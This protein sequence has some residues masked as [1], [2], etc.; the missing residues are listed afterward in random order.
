MLEKEVC[1]YEEGDAVVTFLPLRTENRLQQSLA[2]CGA[3]SLSNK[4]KFNWLQWN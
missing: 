3:I 4:A 1:V 2:E